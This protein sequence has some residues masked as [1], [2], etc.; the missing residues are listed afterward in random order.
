MSLSLDGETFYLYIGY[1]HLF[2]FF[3]DK[4]TFLMDPS[5]NL[6]KYSG[7]LLPAFMLDNFCNKGY[8]T[9]RKRLV[10]AII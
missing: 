8:K 1:F 6:T 7:F 3:K 5:V 4:N 10:I 2:C 9:I